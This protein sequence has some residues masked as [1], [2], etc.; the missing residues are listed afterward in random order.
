MYDGLFGG[1]DGSNGFTQ[2]MKNMLYMG[3]GYD[4]TN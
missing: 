4:G 1:V 3:Y 2:L